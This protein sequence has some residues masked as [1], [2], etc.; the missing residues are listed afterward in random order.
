[1]SQ[2]RDLFEE[3]GFDDVETF[4]ASG[5][6]ALRLP[7]STMRNMKSLRKLVARHID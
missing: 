4:I 3:L 5:V 1:M 6:K 2:L 7:T